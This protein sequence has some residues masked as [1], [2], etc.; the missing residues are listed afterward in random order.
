MLRI[1]TVVSTGHYPP[2]DFTFSL[3]PQAPTYPISS[4]YRCLLPFS[5]QDLKELL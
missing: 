1:T 2:T 4:P 3:I 5:L